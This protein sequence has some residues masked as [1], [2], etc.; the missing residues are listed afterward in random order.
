MI[1]VVKS[2]YVTYYTYWLAYVHL[3]VHLQDKGNL[4]MMD[5]QLDMFLYLVY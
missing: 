1:F 2:I 3:Y 4:I 5:G